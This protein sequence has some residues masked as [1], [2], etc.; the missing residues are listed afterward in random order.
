MTICFLTGQEFIVKYTCLFVHPRFTNAQMTS[1]CTA[2][3]LATQQGH[4]EVVRY[5]V[6]EGGATLRILAYDGMSCVHAAAQMGHLDILEYM[7]LQGT[8]YAI[9]LYPIPRIPASN[10]IIMLMSNTLLS[11]DR[12]I[13]A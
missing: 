9:D 12:K 11:R 3:Y 13:I 5:L 10:K 6:E 2:V 1:G 7:V 8:L 4:L